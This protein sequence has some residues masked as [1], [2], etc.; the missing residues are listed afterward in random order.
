MPFSSSCLLLSIGCSLGK[1]AG[2]VYSSLSLLL[3]LS[4]SFLKK[5]LIFPCLVYQLVIGM[6]ETWVTVLGLI[7]SRSSSL[8]DSRAKAYLFN[9]IILL[10]KF[11][12]LINKVSIKR[13][14]PVCW[15]SLLGLSYYPRWW[16]GLDNL[17]ER[18]GCFTLYKIRCGCNIF[19]RWS[20]NFSEL[21]VC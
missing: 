13:G 2:E 9:I 1:A 20:N 16:R 17:R 5:L 11:I 19:R 10:W 15:C 12:A 18:W 8:L 14:I 3:E 4:I 6:V 21:R 7:W